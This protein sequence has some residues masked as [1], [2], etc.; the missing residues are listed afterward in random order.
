MYMLSTKPQLLEKYDEKMAHKSCSQ[1]MEPLLNAYNIARARAE[2]GEPA[3]ISPN[4]PAIRRFTIL[5]LLVGGEER[6]VFDHL[7]GLPKEL[8][9]HPHIAWAISVATAFA[10]KDYGRFLRLYAEADI[11]SSTIM[12]CLVNL[13]RQRLLWHMVRC[14]A[15][16]VRDKLS[17]EVISRRLAFTDLAVAE[18]FLTFLGLEVIELGTGEKILQLPARKSDKWDI[19]HDEA[20]QAAFNERLGQYHLPVK[21][22]FRRSADGLLHQKYEALPFDRIDIVFGAA[23]SWQEKPVKSVPPSPSISSRRPV[24]AAAALEATGISPALK[25]IQTPPMKVPSRPATPAR[26]LPGTPAAVSVAASPSPAAKNSAR[27]PE[28]AK[29]VSDAATPPPKRGKRRASQGSSA[30]LVDDNNA[31]GNL[32]GVVSST[33]K[34]AAAKQ[35]FSISAAATSPASPISIKD[36]DDD[37]Q[38]PPTALFSFGEAKAP[39]AKATVPV[40]GAAVPAAGA[41]SLLPSPFGAAQP[42]APPSISSMFA[43]TSLTSSKKPEALVASKVY[44]TVTADAPAD[45]DLGKASSSKPKGLAEEPVPKTSFQLRGRSPPS[46]RR[47]SMLQ[48]CTRLSDR[49]A[50]LKIPVSSDAAPRL[51]RIARIFAAWRRSCQERKS[52]SDWVAKDETLGKAPKP[53]Q[54]HSQ[55]RGLAAKKPRLN[56]VNLGEALREAAIRAPERCS[57]SM[58]R[59]G[60]LLPKPLTD[61]TEEGLNQS[62]AL[63][64]TL[65]ESFGALE[66]SFLE[67]AG[68]I[69]SF[70]ELSTESGHLAARLLRRA[71]ESAGSTKVGVSVV[72][73]K[74][75]PSSSSSAVRSKEDAANHGVSAI[76]Q[77]SSLLHILSIPVPVGSSGSATKELKAISWHDEARRV[78][79]TM[80]ALSSDVQNKERTVALLFAASIP[81]S[82]A[83]HG[84][85]PKVLEDLT[86][87]VKDSFKAAVQEELQ[88]A[89][90]RIH[91]DITVEA[92]CVAVTQ[93]RPDGL[94]TGFVSLQGCLARAAAW[95]VRCGGEPALMPKT[96]NLKLAGRLLGHWAQHCLCRFPGGFSFPPSL[97]ELQADF[98]AAVDACV[99]DLQKLMD[100]FS[101]KPPEILRVWSAAGTGSPSKLLEAARRQLWSLRPPLD[102]WRNSH[103]PTAF[104]SAVRSFLEVALPE[105]SAPCPSWWETFAPA[106][107]DLMLLAVVPT[108]PM[109]QAD[110]FFVFA[111]KRPLESS[112]T[113]SEPG[114]ADEARTG[115]AAVDAEK[116][117][118][119]VKTKADEEQMLPPK[120]RR[121][122]ASLSDVLKL[123]SSWSDSLLR[124][125]ALLAANVPTGA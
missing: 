19:M 77:L 47:A 106:W 20:L 25:Q 74:S 16:I 87:Q 35:P 102:V 37:E 84:V 53:Q 59:L 86:C 118:I 111:S 75:T 36:S 24:V 28:M 78:L 91:S 112:E 44:K 27:T 73:I 60:L 49:T 64:S 21:C 79:S 71:E 66:S 93:V 38:P 119:E 105:F 120:K 99:A 32:S 57:L 88:T 45:G 72:E 11:L 62:N 56:A 12:A 17:L 1:I 69:P 80:Q 114:K 55:L 115:A 46:W 29:A 40:F 61:A 90:R 22:E 95:A 58:H 43:P 34:A 116:S 82:S 103:N 124:S 94:P 98:E 125:V 23:D 41:K 48:P 15:P 13:V 67:S 14:T 100:E 107:S 54:Q 26:P 109:L 68:G 63:G 104:W 70:R 18:E 76:G 5:L 39:A 113:A 52:W 33:G 123:D 65:A 81:I 42:S 51:F 92:F 117:H 9:Q 122:V 97:S 2:Q 10:L 31:S 83:A 96:A 6:K 108:Q 85:D 3:Y 50:D 101:S 89:K 7:A 121:R 4:E 30:R 110:R 8:L